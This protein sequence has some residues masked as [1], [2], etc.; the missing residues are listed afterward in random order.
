MTQDA[1]SLLHVA[2][3][4]NT[5][6]KGAKVNKVSQPDKDDL[7]LTLHTFTGNKTLVLSSNAESCRVCF[8][9]A[10]KPNPKT[11]FG[12]CMLMRKHLLGSIVESV[13]LV[14]FERIIRI[15]FAGRNDFKEQV[16]KILYA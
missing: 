2:R 14:G 10:E 4:L 6:L 3:E 5:M 11:A 9:S 12:F 1:F 13:E 7:Y 16:K 15:T 8:T